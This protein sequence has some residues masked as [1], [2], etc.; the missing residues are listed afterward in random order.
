MKPWDRLLQLAADLKDE[1]FLVYG[2]EELRTNY[3]NHYW[4]FGEIYKPDR[5]LETGVRFGY[6]AM[7]LLDGSRASY[8]MGVDIDG[9]R[10]K[11]A[12]ML[13]EDWADWA[14]IELVESDVRDWK[15]EGLEKF[16]LIHLDAY[17]EDVRVEL[18][19][20]ERLI[21]QGGVVIVDD[22]REKWV[23]EPVVEFFRDRNY[24][25][26]HVD[27]LTGQLIGVKQ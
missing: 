8:Y 2:V 16:D 13:I 17:H 9:V 15:Q 7:M 1:E 26:S 25:M 4:R 23:W 21:R 6:T 24:V 3:L 12:K 5:I 18:E 22:V 14:E 27:S 20:A 19:L 10:L 11:A